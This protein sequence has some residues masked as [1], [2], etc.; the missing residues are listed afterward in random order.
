VRG[1]WRYLYRAL[2]R[3]GALVDVML[4]EHRDLAAAK[5]SSDRP[6]RRPASCRIGSPPVAMTPIS[7]RSVLSFVPA[8]VRRWQHMCSTTIALHSCD[9]LSVRCPMASSS[10][11]SGSIT[12]RTGVG[13]YSGTRPSHG[14]ARAAA[15]ELD[16]TP[17]WD[18]PPGAPPVPEAFCH[19]PDALAR[20]H[21]RLPPAKRD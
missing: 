17:R 21:T 3:D 14:V 7:G 19:Q 12:D 11:L 18:L 15:S 5:H 13:S 20:L 9:R 16:V 8:A 4:G 10:Q 2:D 1:R 6:R